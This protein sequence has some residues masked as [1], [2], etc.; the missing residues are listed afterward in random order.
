MPLL[1]LL[2]EAEH[3]QKLPKSPDCEGPNL[4]FI[5]VYDIR[6]K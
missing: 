3:T 1:F 2:T 5:R 6:S 4:P